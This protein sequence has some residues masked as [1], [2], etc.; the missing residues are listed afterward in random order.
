VCTPF[1]GSLMTGQYPLTHGLFMND[2]MLDTAKVTIAEVFAK[3]GYTTG[4][5]GKWHI[6]GHGRSSF[7]PPARR[8]G[9]EYWKALECTHNY[10]HSAYYSGNSDTKLFW[11]G[12]DALAQAADACSYIAENARKHNPFVLFVSM[13]PP[14]NPYQT[15]P[16]EFKKIYADRKIIVNENVPEALRGKVEQDLRG[17]Y[18]HITAIDKGIGDIWQTIKEAGVEEH[19]I[20]VFTADHGDLLGAH[21]SW[22]KQQ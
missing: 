8:Q 21:G 13:G 5:I 15:A 12:Y 16:E 20:V 9:F 18:A 3:Q 19:T 11:D 4:L 17:Y 14:H 7:I 1:R 10:N 2:V 6:D 22:N